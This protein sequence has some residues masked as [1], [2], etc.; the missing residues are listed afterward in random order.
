M[1]VR[2]RAQ[3]GG[4]PIAAV[5]RSSWY[6][7]DGVGAPGVSMGAP[8][9]RTGR[10]SP[11]TELIQE[12][13]PWQ[14]SHRRLLDD[15]DAAFGNFFEEFAPRLRGLARRFRRTED[16]V[17]DLVQEVLLRAYRAEVH[18]EIGSDPWPWLS[19]VCRNLAI[20]A[21]RRR[22]FRGEQSVDDEVFTRLPAAP[23]ILDDP[24]GRT[25]MSGGDIAEALS[26]L[27]ERQ[28]RMLVLK[29]VRGWS[30]EEIA[31]WEGISFPALRSALSRAR[32]KF[33]ETYAAV[34]DRRTVPAIIGSALAPL[35]RRWRSLRNRVVSSEA[36][37]AQHVAAATP[38]LASSVVAAVTLGALAVAG[39]LSG[40]GDRATPP[41]S[42]ADLAVLSAP[43][44]SGAPAPGEPSEAPTGDAEVG[45]ALPPPPDPG[46]PPASE[47]ST[48]VA[49]DAPLPDPD[50]VVDEEDGSLNY[51]DESHD[52]V[53][54]PTPDTRE[55]TDGTR[56][57]FVPVE[58]QSDYDDD[59]E[60]DA[61]FGSETGVNCAAD[62]AE[63]GTVMGT[64]CLLLDTTASDPASDPET[65]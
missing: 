49:V 48:D 60:V 6:G 36:T 40:L 23:D 64:A 52:I 55:T 26:C 24:E 54:D 14:S 18:L 50:L 4:L 10:S 38:G 61:D 9:V 56:H 37:L 12:P 39:T 8:S 41:P 3:G 53:V 47:G 7:S 28:R 1:C 46:P 16:L 27:D 44:P 65:L 11:R 45:S 34:V 29:H 63:Q 19:T 33:T 43:A 13:L 31:E 22:D 35:S 57:E 62:P 15:P 59:G 21:G 51:H 20:D 32:Q 2:H 17:E 42:H 58:R 30:Y 25:V 5:E